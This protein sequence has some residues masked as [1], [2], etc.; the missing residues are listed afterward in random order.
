[1]QIDTNVLDNKL[2]D[3]KPYIDNKL[4]E[5]EGKDKDRLSLFEKEVEFVN[6]LLKDNEEAIFDIDEASVEVGL[7][8]KDGDQHSEALEE[9]IRELDAWTD[10]VKLYQKRGS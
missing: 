3:L 6:K 5:L 1:M 10:K 2:K 8:E 4:K 9:A 7:L